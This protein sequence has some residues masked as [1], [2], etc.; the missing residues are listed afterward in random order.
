M[1]NYCTTCAGKEFV[2]CEQLGAIRRCMKCNAPEAIF[3]IE[4][5]IDPFESPHNKRWDLA[6]AIG[7]SMIQVAAFMDEQ[8]IKQRSSR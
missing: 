3:N 1:K 6:E 7:E 8:E 4:L 5:Y 2:Y